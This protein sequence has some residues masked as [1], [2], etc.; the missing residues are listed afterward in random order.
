MYSFWCPWRH[1]WRHKVPGLHICA[2][3]VQISFSRPNEATVELF[4]GCRRFFVTFGTFYNCFCGR[5][6]PNSR[7]YA[8]NCPYP[9]AKFS[10]QSNSLI[11]WKKLLPENYWA[12]QKRTFDVGTWMT[13]DASLINDVTAWRQSGPS[14]FMFK[15]K[16][17][18]MVN[19][20]I[21]RDTGRS[22][23]AIITKLGPHM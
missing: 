8:S 4:E 21:F 13:D 18:L 20:H 1:Q 10:R 2:S 22:F 16:P 12:C 6:T 15:T 11:Y 5:K 17:P 7:D 23:W 9:V 19:R 14:I 3:A